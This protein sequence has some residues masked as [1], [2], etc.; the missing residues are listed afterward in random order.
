MEKGCIESER[1]AMHVNYRH[2][3]GPLKLAVLDLA[4]TFLDFG[5]CAPAGTFV[6]LFARKGITV[7]DAEARGP[8]GTH[9]RDHIAALCALNGVQKQ[10]KSR[11]GHVPSSADID[12][13]YAAFIPLQIEALPRYSALIPGA[14]EAVAALRRR[15]LRIAF[16]TGYSREMM[17]IVL[18]DAQK[19]GLT[20]DAAVCASDVPT[21]RPAPWMAMECER[22]TAIYP[23]AACIKLGDTIVD[24]EE[25]RN[26]GMWSVGVAV[27]GNMTGLSLVD[28]EAL[29]SEAQQ[30]RRR[31]ARRAMLDAGAHAVIDSIAELPCLVDSINKLMAKG[32][33]ADTTMIPNP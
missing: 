11:Y 3:A 22:L 10:W 28:W 18:A 7:S 27:T 19:Q 24:I 33:A 12:A 8:M 4:G 5:S 29:A 32:G 2:Y 1:I 20:M 26:A 17:N 25:G 21:G 15:G 9:K 6:E 14:R 13:L 31:R 16:T 30:A 23:P